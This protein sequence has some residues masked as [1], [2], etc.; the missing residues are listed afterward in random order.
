MYKNLFTENYEHYINQFIKELKAFE[1]EDMIWSTDGTITN[2]PGTL[3]KHII[4]SLNHFIGFGLGYTDYKRDRPVEFDGS[5]VPRE[6]LISDLEATRK[7]MIEILEKETDFSKPV[8]ASLFGKET[9]LGRFLGKL[10]TH[11]AYHVGQ[12]NYY[13]RALSKE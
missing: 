9:S 8:A 6:Q 13:R 11:L 5:R 10:D 3:A 2:S 7:L 4:G 12:V 1:S